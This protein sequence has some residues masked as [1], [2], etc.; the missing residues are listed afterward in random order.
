MGN[1]EPPSCPRT[2]VNTIAG[3][4]VEKNHNVKIQ[5]KPRRYVTDQSVDP[6]QKTEHCVLMVKAV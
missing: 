6:S 1:S 3:D 2:S 4:P 5:F